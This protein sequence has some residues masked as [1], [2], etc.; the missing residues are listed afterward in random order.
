MPAPTRTTVLGRACQAIP[1]RGEKFQYCGL[2]V[3]PPGLISLN[4]PFCPV[5]GST[6][7]NPRP[8]KK[9]YSKRSNL[10]DTRV[11]HN[12]G[13]FRLGWV[14]L[15]KPFREPSFGLAPASSMQHTS[16]STMPL[17]T[18]APVDSLRT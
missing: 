14:S 6:A 4:T 13:T 9:A 11:T 2:L 8:G 17:P 10:G 12:I 16:A 3:Y 5:V 18:S 7:L 15:G 1:S